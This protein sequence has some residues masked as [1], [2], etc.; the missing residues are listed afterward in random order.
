M[1]KPSFLIAAGPKSYP[2]FLDRLHINR[3]WR[4]VLEG[5]QAGVRW[6]TLHRL[7]ETVT[8]IFGPSG[9]FVH[10]PP[11]GLIPAYTMFAEFCSYT[12]I[13]P[14]FDFSSLVLV[15]FADSLPENVTSDLAIQINGIEWEKYAKDS[16][17]D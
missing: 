3:T 4:G 1:Q 7:P 17:A 5:T 8:H 2:I 6:V 14:E 9:L 16:Y 11:D 10:E 13:K 12:P 15:W